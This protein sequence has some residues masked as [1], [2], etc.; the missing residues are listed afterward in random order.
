MDE[1]GSTAAVLVS[2]E[3][4]LRAH[5]YRFLSRLLAGIP[6]RDTIAAAATL[7][8]D[9]TELGRGLSA[10]SKVAGSSSERDIDDEYH[11]LFVGLGRGELVPYGSYYMTGFLNEKPLAVLRTDMRKLGIARAEG[12]KRSEDHIAALCEMMAG[13]V[14]GDFGAPVDLTGQRDFFFAH[15]APWAGKFFADLEAAESARFY[16]PVGTIGRI[17]MEIE[18]TAFEMVA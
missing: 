14:M 16:M 2:E 8:G 5:Y 10:L 17:F 11:A 1:S 7:E 6:D 9:D 3:D 18:N 4:A 12:V 13:M 15:L